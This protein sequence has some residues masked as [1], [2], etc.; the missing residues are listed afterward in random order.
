MTIAISNSMGPANIACIYQSEKPAPTDRQLQLEETFQDFVAGTFYKQMLKSL[1]KTHGQPAY[2]H[3]GQAEEIFQS[4]L[5]QQVA[6]N[7]ARN[8]GAAFAD[9]MFQAFSR[10]V[11]AKHGDSKSSQVLSPPAS[12]GIT[13]V[14]GVK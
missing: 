1:R 10:Q 7:L 8:H 11:A 9:P 3:G 2:F 14:A 5:D 6:E 12:S 4:Q 13:S